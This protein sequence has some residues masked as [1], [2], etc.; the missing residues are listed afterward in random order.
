MLFMVTSPHGTT[1]FL[2]A[3]EAYAFARK[4]SGL[5]TGKFSVWVDD[6]VE[7]HFRDGAKIGE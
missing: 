6:F 1:H 5:M 4:W 2:V 3:E 7:A